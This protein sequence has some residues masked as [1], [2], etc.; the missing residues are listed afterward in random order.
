MEFL[1]CVIHL[2]LPFIPL[3]DR[4]T[5]IRLQI[6]PDQKHHPPDPGLPR[7]VHRVIQ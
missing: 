1:E 4:L 6:L 3:P 5:E 2:Q 7:I